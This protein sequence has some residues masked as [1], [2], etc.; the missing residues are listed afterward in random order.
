MFCNL[1]DL[2]KKIKSLVAR[3]VLINLYT[4]NQGFKVK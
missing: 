4:I 3:L 2:N 1:Q